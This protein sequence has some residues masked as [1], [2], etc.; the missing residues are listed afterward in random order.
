MEGSLLQIHIP[1]KKRNRDVGST[2]YSLSYCR[3][4][5]TT[6]RMKMNLW[7]SSC[8]RNL[9]TVGNYF[10]FMYVIYFLCSEVY[11]N[12]EMPYVFEDSL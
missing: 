6:D 5:A 2:C 11:D 8:D 12:I 1:Y 10:C 3:K 7:P 4:R 9:E